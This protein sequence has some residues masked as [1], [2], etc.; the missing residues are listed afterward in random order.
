VAC[1]LK[2]QVRRVCIPTVPIII[3]VVIIISSIMSVAFCLTV[4]PVSWIA[5]LYLPDNTP[6]IAIDGGEAK[7]RDRGLVSPL[8]PI[9]TNSFLD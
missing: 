1:S 6:W 5:A 7:V 9:G 4:R 8:S 2:L 3:I